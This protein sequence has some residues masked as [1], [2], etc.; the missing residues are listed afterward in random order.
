MAGSDQVPPAEISSELWS[1][2]TTLFQLER[3]GALWSADISAQESPNRGNT[4]VDAPLPKSKR[5]HYLCNA[6]IDFRNQG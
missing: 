5:V 4:F 2:M 6:W 1:A 3:N